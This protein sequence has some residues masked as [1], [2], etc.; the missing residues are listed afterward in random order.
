MSNGPLL[1]YPVLGASFEIHAMT[2]KKNTSEN[3]IAAATV[4]AIKVV[5]KKANIALMEPIMKLVINAEISVVST[6]IN[7]LLLRRGQILERKDISEG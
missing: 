2:I 3:I 5:L 6:L 4:E 7:D 1:G